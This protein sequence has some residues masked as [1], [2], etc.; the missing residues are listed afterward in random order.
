MNTA[1]IPLRKT[2]TRTSEHAPGTPEYY[3]ELETAYSGLAA[4]RNARPFREDYKCP[5]CMDN[6]GLWSVVKV[7]GCPQLAYSICACRK[8]ENGSKDMDEYSA[9]EPWQKRIK[10]SA[11]R[12]VRTATHL[13]WF[14]I[15]GQVGSGKS[16][17]CSAIGKAMTA[18]GLGVQTMKW[19]ESSRRL[20]AS[21]MEWTYENEL[22]TFQHAPVLVVDDF[23]LTDPTE[24][25]VRLARELFD[26]RYDHELMTIINS[27]KNLA[28]VRSID[29]GLYSRIKERAGGYINN[30]RK[31]KSR[32][33][34]TK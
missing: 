3:K 23:F 17:I 7:A 30:V 18:K 27:E 32:D 20:K 6:G 13:N 31:D 4:F 29:E 11:E 2:M 24:A 14:Y 28:E 1:Q 21:V 9:E 19:N 34:R 25:D 12:F 8:S 15:G 26:F 16:H 22:R 5:M 33:W 10:D